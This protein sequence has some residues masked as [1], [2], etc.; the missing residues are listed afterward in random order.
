M[1]VHATDYNIAMVHN[2]SVQGT[3]LHLDTDSRHKEIH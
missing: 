1:L 3:I 2:R